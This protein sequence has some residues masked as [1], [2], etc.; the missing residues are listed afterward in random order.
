MLLRQVVALLLLP[1]VWAANGVELTLHSLEAPDHILQVVGGDLSLWSGPRDFYTVVAITSS[2][3]RHACEACGVFDKMMRR[4]ARLWFADHADSHYVFFVSVDIANNN[5]NIFEHLDI[6]TIPQVRL[7]PPSTD[8][9]D[10]GPHALFNS[11]HLQYHIPME[12]FDTQAL[13]FAH[14]I[15]TNVHRNILLR[16][17]DSTTLFVRS[18]GLT[19]LVILLIKKRG[20]SVVTGNLSKKKVYMVLCILATVAFTSGYSFSVMQRVP[21]VAKN[22]HDEI[23]LI[24]GGS[25]YQLSVEILLVGAVYVALASCV[26]AL[27]KLGNTNEH[28]QAVMVVGLTGGVYL[29]YSVLTSMVS[30][31]DP[32]YPYHFTKVF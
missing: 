8:K 28:L 31:K 9:V 30:R 6:Q 16:A 27:I 29:L 32:G 10:F 19:F 20:P 2:D 22:D 4:V 18:F 21:F 3:P 24:A 11:E 1:I 14:F 12:S 17:E 7:I 13:D 25:H 23:V 15:S 5:Q 26:V